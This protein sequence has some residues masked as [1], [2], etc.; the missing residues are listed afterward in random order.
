MFHSALQGDSNGTEGGLLQ[1][2]W[3]SFTVWV[4]IAVARVWPEYANSPT[5]LPFSSLGCLDIWHE[6]EHMLG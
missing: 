5:G 6:R 2:S 4:C 1:G 3:A